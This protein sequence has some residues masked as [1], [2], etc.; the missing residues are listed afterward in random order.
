MSNNHDI[1]YI[2]NDLLLMNGQSLLHN[3][4]I[5]MDSNVT[6]WNTTSKQLWRNHIIISLAINAY[7]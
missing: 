6:T 3:Q 7:V 2:A 5:Y 4:A 1:C